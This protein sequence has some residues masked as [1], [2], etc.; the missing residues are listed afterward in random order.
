M[1]IRRRFPVATYGLSPDYT[2]LD[3]AFG[4]V[5]RGDLPRARL[6][7]VLE[8]CRQL[9]TDWGPAAVRIVIE[10]DTGMFIVSLGR[11][12][13]WIARENDPP[14][15][16]LA[17]TAQQVIER[18]EQPIKI[19]VAPPPRPVEPISHSAMTLVLLCTGV[20]LLVVALKPVFS[21]E[22]TPLSP[23]VDV[24]P[25]TDPADREARQA[26]VR[27]LFA[28]GQQTGDRHLTIS[29]DGYVVFAE[30]GPRQSLGAG[31]DSFT[32]VRRDQQTGLLT[33]RS[34]LIEAIDRN[35]LLYFGDT[36]RRVT[37]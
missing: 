23:P 6:L 25:V 20:I 16:R 8:L 18:V 4:H 9:D 34:G 21:P 24:E 10:G 11:K 15:Q 5:N 17:V 31:A 37:K 13:L 12:Q 35:T 29:A 30:L 1:K 28:T 7:E 27:G 14:A 3:P 19:T 32:I 22:I 26:A 36:Y 2:R 33:T